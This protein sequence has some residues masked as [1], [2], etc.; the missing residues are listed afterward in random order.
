MQKLRKK[1]R[2]VS[3]TET[4]K[5][6]FILV[7]W[8]MNWRDLDMGWLSRIREEGDIQP[9]VMCNQ[10][11]SGLVFMRKWKEEQALFC[12]VRIYHL[13]RNWQSAKTSKD[14]LVFC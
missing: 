7:S 5:K 2:E 6:G 12:A 13:E 4:H 14:F 10:D 3:A 8:K 11:N 1:G 9:P